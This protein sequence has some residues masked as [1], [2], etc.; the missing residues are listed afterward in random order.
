VIR[1]A[2][3]R[4][5]AWPDSKR[6]DNQALH[7]VVDAFQEAL[8]AG[9]ALDDAIDAAI[10]A[11][12]AVPASIARDTDGAETTL[13]QIPAAPPTELDPMLR[14]AEDHAATRSDAA[15][16]VGAV[17]TDAGRQS[18]LAR[19][20]EL[21]GSPAP[22]ARIAAKEALNECDAAGIETD[23]TSPI[24]LAPEALRAVLDELICEL[25]G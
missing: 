15:V 10:A 24:A 17:V 19:A 8:D 4:G 25:E 23:V 6:G 5:S 2:I 11:A 9:E 12:V 16:V 3:I 18:G 20:E 14:S 13:G 21:G 7:A 1:E 22:A